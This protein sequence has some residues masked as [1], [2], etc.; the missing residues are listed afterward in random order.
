MRAVCIDAGDSAVL[1]VGETYHVFFNGSSHLYVSKFDNEKAHFGCF[2]VTQFGILA[3]SDKPDVSQ[4]WPEEPLGK[5]LDI[6]PDTVYKAQL[7]Y[8][9][10]GYIH[11]ELGTYYLKPKKTHAFFYKDKELQNLMGMFPL[12]WF[13][14]FEKVE[15]EID[16][17][18]VFEEPEE[19][20]ADEWQ[21]MSLF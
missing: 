15:R 11:K 12:H 8:R 20:P 10:E 5:V 4:D 7:I 21:Q 16:N 9:S 17:E 6:E 14:Q 1:Q 13:D 2:Q 19:L 3:D 18:K